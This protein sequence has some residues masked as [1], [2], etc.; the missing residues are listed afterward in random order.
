MRSA[1]NKE[2]ASANVRDVNKA[3][4]AKYMKEAPWGIGIGIFADNIP[5]WN[6]YKI[7]SQI[8]PDSEYVFIWVRT[9]KIGITWFIICNLIMFISACCIVF[10]RIRNKSLMG[11]GAGWCAAFIALHLGGYANQILMQFP[12]VLIFYGGLTTVFILPRIEHQFEQYEEKLLAKEAEKKRLK[13]EKKRAKR[14]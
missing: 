13:L 10:F 14:V 11:V 4:I 12:N 1:F 8:P 7:V 2:D 3:A 9:G 6:K 5:A